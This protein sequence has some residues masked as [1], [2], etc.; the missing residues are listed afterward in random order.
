MLGPM[1]RPA[2]TEPERLLASAALAALGVADEHAPMGDGS[3]LTGASGRQLALYAP[4]G[5]SSCLTI[6]I[7]ASADTAAAALASPYQR[8]RVPQD[9]SAQTVGYV[10]DVDQ[11]TIR[12]VCLDVDVAPG[13]PPVAGLQWGQPIVP[14]PLP[15]TAV[16]DLDEEEAEALTEILEAFGAQE[17]PVRAGEPLP[18]GMIH[19]PSLGARAL[20]IMGEPGSVRGI[21]LYDDLADALTMASAA[22][23]FGLIPQAGGKPLA[24]GYLV[25]LPAM[26]VYPLGVALDEPMDLDDLPRP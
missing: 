25:T 20:A 18:A 3:D 13:T 12:P 4:A 14:G 15:D 10:I 5:A 19:L 26:R 21:E 9:L 17:T 2:L 11:R 7:H 24:N 16:P 1:T 8:H 22:S 23:R 6:Q